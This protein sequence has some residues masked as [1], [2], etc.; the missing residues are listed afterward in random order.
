MK[1]PLEIFR[2]FFNK[3]EKSAAVSRFEG[4]DLGAGRF[5]C[6]LSSV[7][8]TGECAD[9]FLDV[10][11]PDAI[12]DILARAGIMDHLNKKGL[13]DPL[14][15]TE[16][17][18]AG[19]HRLRVFFGRSAPGRLLIDLRL[20]RLTYLPAGHRGTG[21][22]GDGRINALAIEWICLQDPR[23]RF[24]RERP[25]LPGQTYPG[26]GAV[27]FLAPLMK[28]FAADLGAGAVLD[29]PEHYH[30]AVMYSGSFRFADPER[31]GML[32]AAVRDLRGFPLAAVSRAFS[33]GAVRDA[34]TGT[35]VLF[36]PSEQVLPVADELVRHFSSREYR[37]RA[38][39][40][41]ERTV[42]VLGHRSGPGGKKRP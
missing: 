18:P 4:F 35:P 8:G 37:Q 24:T 23:A 2:S 9:L 28:L 20:S 21:A 14:I 39:A 3:K 42:L 36:T 10:Y 41:A 29:V 22:I 6:T 5:E 38:D 32:R 34:R 7:S 30:A 33:A 31:E 25:R 40:A 17:D 1:S 12:R 26:L 19:I 16:K 15:E 27:R 13:T 11:T